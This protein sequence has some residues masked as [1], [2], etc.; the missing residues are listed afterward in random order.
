MKECLETIKA[1]K[2]EAFMRV[3]LKG[4][5]SNRL[6]VDLNWILRICT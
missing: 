1:P 5:S 6:L 4:L 3:S 2:K